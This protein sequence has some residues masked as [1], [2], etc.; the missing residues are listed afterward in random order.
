MMTQYDD[1]TIF[2]AAERGDT[3]VIQNWFSTGTRDADARLDGNSDWTLLYTAAFGGHVMT[4]RVLLAHGASVS[5]VNDHGMTPLHAACYYGHFHAAALLLERGAQVDA[6]DEDGWTP[7][8]N[9]GMGLKKKMCRLM[10]HH[11]ANINACDNNGRNFERFA[12]ASTNSEEICAFLAD[13]RRAG[14]WRG[15]VRY[16]RFRL[17]MLR[18]L[19]ERGRA[20]TKDDL[21]V[22]VFPGP[23][24][25]LDSER[26]TRASKRNASIVRTQLP[27]EVFWLIVSYWRSS[28]D[29]DA[30]APDVEPREERALQAAAAKAAED[31]RAEEIYQFLAATAGLPLANVLEMF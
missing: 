25:K 11:G 31:T 9:S 15:Y 13:V 5:I 30:S 20:D 4:M 23:P 1:E 24:K 29:Y 10:F 22:R 18:I 14:G 19:A 28:R 6:R 27:K 16:P 3:A 12:S 17:L 21:L 26:R 8:M 2:A 7:L